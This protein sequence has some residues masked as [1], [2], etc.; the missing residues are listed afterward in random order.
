MNLRIRQLT[1]GLIVIY[2]ILFIQLNVVQLLRADELRSHPANTRDIV[3]QFSEP[4][5]EIATSDGRVVARS[6]E[7]EG[8]LARLREYPQGELYAHITGYLSLN[9]GASGLERRLNDELAGATTE[10]EIKS[11]SDLFVERDR[12]ADVTLTINHEVQRIAKA[13]LGDRKGSVVA[14]DPRTGEILA[15]W[16]W[17][18][19][20]PNLLSTHDLSAAA[21]ARNEL[22]ADDDKPLLARSYQERFAPGSTFKAVTA[23]AALEAGAVTPTDP[24]FEVV[25]EYIAP[26]TDRPITNFGLAACGGDLTEMLRV[27]CNTGFAKLGVDIGADRLAISARAFGFNSA[28]PI[29]LPDPAESV[30]PR[31]SFFEDN[32]ALLAQSAIGQFDTAATPLQ[33]AMVAAAI[34]NDGVMMVP[35]VVSRI[36][37]SDGELIEETR[38]SV[39]AT[40]IGFETAR[41]LSEMLE[42]VVQAGTASS[43]QLP[44]VRVAGKTGTAELGDSE[45]THAWIIGFAPVEAPRVA[46]AVIVEGDDSTGQLTGGAVAGPIAAEVL[47]TALEVTGGG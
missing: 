5:G 36:T 31:A 29:D 14:V 26:Q 11:F 28:L 41:Q 39:L 27:S 4:R 44:G 18:S 13:A 1:L 24:L 2:A 46:F 7:L 47:R 6:I 15:L 37:D 40:P 20:D 23:A 12:T 34:A 25:T 10:I 43:L 33:M 32:V 38:P 30:F 17:P 22:L 19:F 9:F 16:S 21:M 3:R 45:G 8:D 42:N 35:H